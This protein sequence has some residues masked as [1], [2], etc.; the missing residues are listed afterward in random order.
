MSARMPMMDELEEL[1]KLK[2]DKGFAEAELK[3]VRAKKVT[4]EGDKERQQQK[5]KAL[6]VEAA[7]YDEG[8]Q[9][10]K[11]EWETQVKNADFLFSKMDAIKK[12]LQILMDQ[13]SA[14]ELKSGRTAESFFKLEIAAQTQYREVGDFINLLDRFKSQRA[15][16]LWR[17]FGERV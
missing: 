9:E 17:E 5:I 2:A 10:I 4:S 1:R 3:S 11:Q 8:I 16:D 13:Y 7:F 15:A 12:T 14:I 6:I